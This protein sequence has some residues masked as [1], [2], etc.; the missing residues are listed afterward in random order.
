[1]F[2]FDNSDG[3][4]RHVECPYMW[5]NGSHYERIMKDM[6]GNICGEKGGGIH[7]TSTNGIDWTI[8]EQPL[9]Y[10]RTVTWDDGQT[11]RQGSFER[12]QLLIK[13]GIPTHLFAATADGPGGFHKAENTWNICIPLGNHTEAKPKY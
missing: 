4:K 11:I 8:S 9:A 12:P 2:E 13:N 5:W 10:S 1:M 7:A 6:G 3:V